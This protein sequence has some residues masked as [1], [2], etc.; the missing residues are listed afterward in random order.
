MDVNP[1]QPSLFTPGCT[2]KRGTDDAPEH[3]TPTVRRSRIG[4]DCRDYFTPVTQGT[5]AFGTPEFSSARY[6]AMPAK[7]ALRTTHNFCGPASASHPAM[8]TPAAN[9]ILRRFTRP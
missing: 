5:D 3:A 6:A 1:S 9:R 7:N 4:G 2:R 8:H